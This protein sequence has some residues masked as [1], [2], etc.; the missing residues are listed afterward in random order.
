MNKCKGTNCKAIDGVGHSEECLAE[1]DEAT[2][3]GDGMKT[4]YKNCHPE[5]AASLQL[6]EHIECILWDR[7]DDSR[8][9]E[10]TVV[11][12]T[13]GSEDHTN[14]LTMDGDYWDCAIPH[15]T[16]TYV[17][18]AVS[19]VKGLVDRGYEPTMAGEWCK[20]GV[21][22][23]PRLF[24]YCDKPHDLANADLKDWMLIDKETE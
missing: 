21:R 24:T 4:S 19:M 1:H 14:Y 3:C 18:D 12:Y 9:Y 16:E 13:G 6:G 10:Q 17:I 22:F 7:K 8:K 15:K 20:D 23:L 2:R 11:A 5:I